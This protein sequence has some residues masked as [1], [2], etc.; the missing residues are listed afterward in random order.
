[1]E[2][3][4]IRMVLSLAAV[5]ALMVGL[6]Y[7]VKRFVLPGTGSLRMPVQVD[8]IGKR[9]LQPKKSVFV[10]RVAGKVLVLGV[11]DHGMQTLTELTEEE[12][13][14][15][16]PESSHAPAAGHVPFSAYLQDTLRTIRRRQ[17]TEVGA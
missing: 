10:V 8:V 2:G 11:S 4:L 9:T 17:N 16:A 5:L 14:A 15:T 3:I 1:M 12:L 13:R 7:L 6:M